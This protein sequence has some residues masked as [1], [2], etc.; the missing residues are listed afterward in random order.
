M[1]NLNIGNE[2][3]VK[4]YKVYL[5]RRFP[6][7]STVVHYESDMKSFLNYYKGSLAEVKRADIDGY[8]DE[9]RREGRSGATVKRRAAALKTFFDFVDEEI[10]QPGRENPVSMK[11][12]GGRPG[13]QLPRSLS[14]EEV[15]RLLAVVEDKRDRAMVM[16]ML[17]GGLR[18]EEVVNLRREDI[19]VPAEESQAVQL[20][21]L[22]KGRKERVVY[23]RRE[24]YQV[25]EAYLADQRA[26]SAGQPLFLNQRGEGL[27]IAGIQ[28]VMREYARVSQVAVTCHQLRHT[29]ARWLAEGEMPLLSLS[30]F[31]GHSSLA[32]TQR[33][34][35]GANPQLR[36]HYDQAMQPVQESSLTQLPPPPSTPSLSA[37]AG[38]PVVEAVSNQP[39]V[40]RPEPATFQ[41]P[42][43]V[44]EWP[45]WLQ[46][47]CL[48]WLNH[49][50]LQ[51]KPSRRSHHLQVTL[52][53][54]RT[55]WRWQ[56]ARRPF[57]GW[58]EL[59]SADVAAFL[60]AEL[61]RGLAARTLS[62]LLD[63]VYAVLHFLADKQQLD[64]LPPRP[65]LTWPDS[66]P[67]HLQ[68]AELLALET[69]V[70]Q[71]AGQTDH[72]PWLT[73][74]LY[75]VLAHAGLR[76]GEALDLQCQDLDLAQRRLL[77]RQGKGLKDRLVYLTPTAVQALTAYLQTVPHAPTDLLFSFNQAPLSY[78][79]ALARLRLLGLAAGVPNLSPLRLRHTYA[80]TLLNNGM[81]LDALRLL[82][83]H[84]H[85]NTTL[86][87]ARLA[88]STVENQYQAAMENISY[89]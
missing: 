70:R 84:A 82:M 16:L 56:L 31:L 37:V 89:R 57:A 88:D 63:Q 80:T 4:K 26:W 3:W 29:C 79:Q 65:Q 54:L 81:T 1:N 48:A 67:R 76:I 43:W 85:L 11:R 72:L 24:A 13:K 52:N 41:P 22:G 86:I 14:D 15:E 59:T 7:R 28:W 21:V 33:Y 62:T 61:A 36:R 49:R 66:L 38:L 47:S 19:T 55:F 71:H 39:T 12:H 27:T 17:Y 87:Y 35:E 18:V 34:L 10:G 8:V 2:E 78:H 44:V 5:Q 51:W 6:G 68:P 77:I 9:Q 30:R 32:S 40:V 42:A 45:A 25:V 64:R 58:Q 23:L 73:V 74:A 69:Y 53:Q 75:F 60:T 46:D 83:G 20:R 50:W